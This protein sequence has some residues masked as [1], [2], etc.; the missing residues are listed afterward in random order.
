METGYFLD[1]QFVPSLMKLSA[2]DSQRVMKAIDK[3]TKAPESP[4]LNLEQLEGRTGKRRL[5]TIRASQ[6]LR[7]LLVRDGPTWVFLRAGHHDEI[8]DL[9]ERRTFV[10]PVDGHPGLISIRPTPPDSGDS[11]LDRVAEPRQSPYDNK[12][13]IVEHW[14]TGELARA[15]FSEDEIDRLRRTTQDTLLEVWP[16]I[17]DEMLDRVIECSEMSPDEWFAR[18]LFADEADNES[19]HKRFRDAIVEQG[20]LAGL[21]SLLSQQ[22]LQRLMSAPIEDWMIFLHPDQ[23]ALVERRFSGP[24]RVRGSAGTGKTVVALHRAA[25]LAK[26]FTGS[27]GRDGRAPP[28]ILFTTFV[29]SLTPVLRNLYH[30]LPT[31]VAG[32]VE[33][34]NVDS[35]ASRIC[36]QFDQSPRI[37]PDTAN[38]GFEAAFSVVVRA[39]TPLQR[40]GLTRDY[41]REEVTAVLKGR[42]VDSLEEY[43]NLER[44]GRRM[45]FTAAMRAQAW[46]LREE[47]DKRLREA[48]IMDFPDVVREARDLAR[49]HREPMYCAAI[50]DESQDLTLVGLQLV[51]AL[52]ARGK[53]NDEADALFIVGDGAQK[54]YPGG[55]TLAQ[56]GLNIRGNSAVLRVNYRNTRPIIRA[57]MA[58]A[59][60]ETVNDLGDEYRRGD[61]SPVALREGGRP[62]LVCAGNLSGQIA[63]VAAE[64]NH[65]CTGGD[66]GP[67][68]VGVFA[69][70]N[71]AVDRTLN[72]LAGHGINCQNLRGFDGRPNRS[73]KVGTFHRAKGLEFKVVFLLGLSDQ[74][75]PRP[76]RRGQS[77][78]EYQEQRALQ[79]SEL[80][81]AMTRARDGL[82]L[83]CDE[84]PSGVLYEA[85]DYLDEEKAGGCRGQRLE[86]REVMSVTKLRL[87]GFDE[88]GVCGT[89]NL[90]L[91]CN[92]ESGGKLAIWGS[93]DVRGN[94]DAVLKAGL[95]CTVECEWIAPNPEM[96]EKFGH[97]YWVPQH[98]SLRIVDAT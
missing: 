24:A 88:G 10:V 33:F 55:Y 69:S 21:S 42:G 87:I 58:C 18:D 25:V 14:T 16:T 44:T 81:V 68:D 97:A 52:V 92:L 36:R 86:K 28:S 59:G 48:G 2:S 72:H 45:P 11:A 49:D 95:P 39:G 56:A 32:A 13:T 79:L 80:F 94:I 64:I 41:L 90:R 37:D 22:E 70:S 46:T 29:R 6:E 27:G 34:V 61:A 3:Y 77:D 15:G 96:A 66:L 73:V 17:T 98:C 91:V 31:S 54:I 83:L 62:R 35:L 38:K 4:G 85:L 53:E 60:S 23:R 71:A 7:V 20:A 30:R 78:A 65:L 51:Q 74:S 19:R 76:R 50:V 84:E 63:H 40:A 67:G 8:Y 82:F 47:W 1:K 5:W 75:F 93:P 43:L 9:A 57:A 89:Q 12:P 26:R